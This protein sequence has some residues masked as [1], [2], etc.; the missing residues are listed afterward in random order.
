MT[1]FSSD[2]GID[3]LWLG[4]HGANGAWRYARSV[5]P[6]LEDI[7]AARA[8]GAWDLCVEACAKALYAI[9]VCHCSLDGMQ[10]VPEREHL[11]ALIASSGHPVAAALRALPLSYRATEADAERAHAAVDEQDAV[12]RA[13][14]P[15][16]LPVIRQAGRHAATVRV[17]AQIGRFRSARGL[18]A[19]DW[20][21]SGL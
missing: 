13:R 5:D 1:F 21:R 18:G 12:L 15:F 14:L 9:L 8:T 10:G 11:H 19:L 4:T 20:D 7:E 16:E 2:D 6:T 3:G 17:T